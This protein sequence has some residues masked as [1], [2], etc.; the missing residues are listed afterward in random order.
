MSKNKSNSKELT[1]KCM[2]EGIRSLNQDK[3]PYVDWCFYKNLLYFKECVDVPNNGYYRLAKAVISANVSSGSAIHRNEV[4]TK[5]RD[6]K[7]KIEKSELAKLI[8][9]A[10]RVSRDYNASI[11]QALY[12]VIQFDLEQKEIGKTLQLS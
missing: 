11:N 2:S 4:I 1:I 8:K 7:V 10:E 3:T 12:N 6:E 5:D 9:L